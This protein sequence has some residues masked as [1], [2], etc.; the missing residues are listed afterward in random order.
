FQKHESSYMQTVPP[1]PRGAFGQSSPDVERGMQWTRSPRLTCEVMRR[2][3]R[4]GLAPSWQVLSRR[5][6]NP[7]ATVTQKPVSPVRSRH[8]PLTPLRRECRCF[9]FICGDYTCVLISLHTRLRVQPN[10]RHSLRPLF[11]RGRTACKD[12]GAICAA[13]TRRCVFGHA[14]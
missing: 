13:G 11:A 12:S 9:G 1:R 10:T 2:P 8:K 7:L 4:V 3:K 14:P 6:M 5:T